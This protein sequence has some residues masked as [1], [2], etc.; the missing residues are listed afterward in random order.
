MA[1]GDTLIVDATHY[2]IAAIKKY[3]SLCNQYGYS[4][5]VINFA[6]NLEEHISIAKERNLLRDSYKQVPEEV[7]ERMAN[8]MLAE[9]EE[10]E[11]SFKI[12]TPEEFLTLENF[13][14]FD[15]NQYE[16][17][18]CFGDIHGCL[19]PLSEYFKENPINKETKYIF[20]GDYI[21]RGIQNEAT[22]KFLMPLIDKENFTFLEGNHEKWLR[23]FYKDEINRI[24]SKEFLNNTMAQLKEIPKDEIRHFVKRLKTFRYFTFNG[25]NFLVSHGGIPSLPNLFMNEK[26]FINGTGKYEN[27][28]TV[29][30]TF[31]ENTKDF[32][33]PC[34]QIHGH[35][36]I[37]K[38]PTKNTPF[39]YNLEGKIEFGG[40]LRVVEIT[41]DEII[42]KEIQNHIFLDK[43]SNEEI[44]KSLKAS[45][46]VGE[47]ELDNG[48]SSFNFTKESFYDNKWNSL[49]TKARGLFVD[50]ESNKI[51]AR[52]YPKFFNLGEMPETSEENLEKNLK[53][54]VFG[55]KKENGYLGLLSWNPKTN[56]YFIASK[57][58]NKGDYA[59]NF[60]RILTNKYKIQENDFLKGYLSS[61]PVT[62]IFEVID[63]V[64]D[65][66]IIEYSEEKVVLL[67]IVGNSFKEDFMEYTSSGLPAFAKNFGFEVKKKD[68]TADNFLEL[69]SR[70]EERKLERFEGWVIEDSSGFRFKVK[71]P[72]YVFWKFLRNKF[73]NLENISPLCKDLFKEEIEYVKAFPEERKAEFIENGQFR[74][75]KFYKEFYEGEK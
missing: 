53:F 66:H 29:D 72:F 71:T 27:S 49:N 35:R 44:I 20:V 60:K 47:K 41:K 50:T 12:I 23:H 24:V 21:D 2:N 68:F 52:S 5:N 8:V 32:K 38:V 11:K 1:K 10:F 3:K 25:K 7:I 75:I 31:C 39:T 65:P 48:I 74:I 58:T 69:Q 17:I 59:E 16:K 18:V 13:Q 42:T 67:D 34:Y 62:L 36:N 61:V 4:I 33:C 9:K 40:F 26:E 37:Q 45:P 19:E 64:F 46:L 28:E 70:L 30:N 14:P 56:D 22:L 73:L 54:P 63:P 51:I 57:S 43:N 55:W 6:E 15:Y